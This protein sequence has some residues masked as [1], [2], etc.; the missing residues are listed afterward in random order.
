VLMT[1]GEAHAEIES[2]KLLHIAAAEPLLAGMP[3]GRW[4]GGSTEY[5][6]GEGGGV[7]TDE[8]VSVMELPFA[9]ARIVTYDAPSIDRIAQDAY[10][11]GFTI[12]ILPFDSP[13]HRRFALESEDFP[14]LFANPVCG[15]ISGYNLASARKFAVSVNGETGTVSATEAVALHVG[16]PD[17]RMAT[18]DVV[19]I[20]EPDKDHAIVVFPK[21]GLE[22]RD[23][24]MN[25]R[26]INFAKLMRERGTDTSLPLVGTFAGETVNVSFKHVTDDMVYLYAPVKAGLEYRIAAPVDDYAATFR[27]RLEGIDKQDYVFACNCILN[28]L[29]GK[30]EGEDI[31]GL[32]GPVTFGEV[33]WHLV[34]QTLVYLRVE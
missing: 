29:N 21:D 4:I 8:L 15:W 3:Q 6:L 27:A 22:V 20:F 19:N 7:V 34:N 26:S 30:M 1:P 13:V 24:L 18:L 32:Y 25:G 5:F 2:G 28:F 23:C 9:D 33:A 31:G 12:V 14:G 11:N 17:D 10:E 16:L